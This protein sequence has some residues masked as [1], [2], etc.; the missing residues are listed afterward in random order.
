MWIDANHNGIQDANEKGIPGATITMTD[1]AGNPV[2]D[3]NGNAV[4]PADDRRNGKYE[5]TNLP[6]GQYV[7]HI[8]YSTVPAGLVPTLTGQ[9]TTATDSSTGSAT[10][11]VLPVRRAGPDPGL[12]ALVADAGDH[13]H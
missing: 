1:L 2:K 4:G 10:S 11:A 13:D 7:T 5:F 8:D 9:G 6:P 12:R 3:I